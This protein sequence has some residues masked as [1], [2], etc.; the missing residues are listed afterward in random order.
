MGMAPLGTSVPVGHMLR[1]C[2]ANLRADIDMVVADTVRAVE[3]GIPEYA[4]PADEAYHRTL[5][6]G[7]EQALHGFLGILERRDDT[8][9]RD[10]YRAIGAGEMREGRSLDALQAAI[11]IGAR[12]GLRHVVEFAE[13]ESLTPGMVGSL[14][15]AIW[16]HVDDLAEAAA[17]GYAEARAAEVGDLDRRRRR[18]LHLLVADPPAGDEAVAAAALAARW[19]MPRRLAA[20]A[21]A[22]GEVQTLPPVLPPDVLADPRH[23]EPV[24]IVPDPESPAQLRLMVNTL[25][26]YRVAVGPAVPPEAAGHSLR[27]ARRALDLHGRGVIGGDGVIWCQEHLGILAVFQDEA[28]LAALVERRLSPLAAM[29]ASQR[30]PLVDTLLSWLQHNMNAN[31]VAAHLHLHP[32][33]VRRRLRQLDRL[34]G[35]RIHDGDARFELEIALLAEQ[36]GRAERVRH[37]KR[38][39]P[40]PHP[41]AARVTRPGAPA[42]RRAR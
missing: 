27:W 16:S 4:R 42:V 30:E 40:A 5:H 17:E 34:F 22:P 33:T 12:M 7:V 1:R 13:S 25:A 9:W 15:D 19:P 35:E 29:R 31:A 3:S 18:L 26:R 21:I 11:R 20:V 2:A 24:L 41:A 8:T 37:A 38:D 14:A 10:V 39:E 23:A 28:L 32:Q 36:A 6:A